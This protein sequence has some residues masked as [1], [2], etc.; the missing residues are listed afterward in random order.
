MH[1]AVM[2]EARKHTPLCNVDPGELFVVEDAEI[3][4][5]EFAPVRCHGKLAY[6]AWTSS[7][8]RH[9]AIIPDGAGYRLFQV[10]GAECDSPIIRDWRYDREG[11]HV[12]SAAPM[13]ASAGC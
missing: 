5:Y 11:R 10:V 6:I 2:A 7:L 1:S 13:L 9:A 4:W 8:L 3:K 12:E